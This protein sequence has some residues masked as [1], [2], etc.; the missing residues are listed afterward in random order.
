MTLGKFQLFNLIKISTILFQLFFKLLHLFLLTSSFLIKYINAG[1][2]FTDFV[3]I[4]LSI[5]ISS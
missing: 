2:Y 4:V 1:K 3:I 5:E